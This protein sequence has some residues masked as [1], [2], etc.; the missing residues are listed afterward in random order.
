[1]TKKMALFTFVYSW[2][3]DENRLH[4]R[5]NFSIVCTSRPLAVL[6]SQKQ[7][8]FISADFYHFCGVFAGVTAPKTEFCLKIFLSYLNNDVVLLLPLFGLRYS[9][10]L[11]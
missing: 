6:I 1:M 3:A 2:H 7:R 11:Y 4:S 5:P 9:R 8:S 10:D